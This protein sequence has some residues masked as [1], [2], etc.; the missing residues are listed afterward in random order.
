MLCNAEL[1][2]PV[3]G[4]LNRGIS[5]LFFGENAWISSDIWVTGCML[6]L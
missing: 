3:L 2:Y 5:F 1:L 4:L 6:L